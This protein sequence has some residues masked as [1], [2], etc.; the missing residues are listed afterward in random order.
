MYETRSTYKIYIPDHKYMYTWYSYAY[1]A[2][3]NKELV[4]IMHADSPGPLI[5]LE[6]LPSGKATMSSKKH[7]TNSKLLYKSMFPV[8]IKQDPL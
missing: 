6:C 3:W 2:Q 7:H 5:T 1:N 4:I 8:R